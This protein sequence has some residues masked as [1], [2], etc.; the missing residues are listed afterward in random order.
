MMKNSLLGT[1][2]DEKMYMEPRSIL[3]ETVE[4]GSKISMVGAIDHRVED[5]HNA[6]LFHKS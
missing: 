2:T 1:I 5:T 6:A 3:H 4:Y